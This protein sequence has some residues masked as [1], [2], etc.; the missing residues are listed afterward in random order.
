MNIYLR[1]G[2]ISMAVVCM[3][4]A[5]GCD[6]GQEGGSAT[7]GTMTLGMMPK[8]VGI[9]YFTSAEDGAREAAKELNVDLKFDGPMEG[10]SAAQ[11]EMLDTWITRKTDVIAISPNDPNA[12]APTLKKAQER[13]IQVITYDADAALEARSYFVNQA[14]NESVGS[15]LVDV[16]AEQLGGPGEV[17]IITGSMTA[18]NQNAWID[19]M[20]ERIAAAHPGMKIVDIRPSELDP[21]AAYRVTQDLLKAYPNLKG[22]FGLTSIALPMAAQAVKEAGRSGTITVTGLATPSAMKPYIADGTVKAFLLW[23]PVDLG[24]LTVYVA[25]AV[26]GGQKLG[27]TLQA[28]RLGD[29]MVSGT[30]VLLGPPLRFDK[31]NIDK[32]NF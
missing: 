23:S 1:T 10:D 2:M 5:P 6:K 19:A 18:A 13:G 25:K 31:G 16:M 21:E 4:F 28:G 17:A 22:I 15:G 8:L 11:A 27:N 26:A 14:T 29:V 24:Y 30:E 20:K 3:I 12:I 9:D 7:K 32:Y